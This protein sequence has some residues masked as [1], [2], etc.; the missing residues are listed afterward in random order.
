MTGFLFFSIIVLACVPPVSKD[1]LVHHLAV[2][3]LYLKHGKI[4]EI[5]FMP[6]SYYP[7]NLDMLYLIPLYFGNDIIPKYIHFSFALL[8]GLC[9]FE[10]LRRRTRLVYGL[11]GFLFFLSIPIIVKLSITAYVD[12][13]LIFFSTASLLLLLR[14]IASGFKWRF[15]ILS[16]ILCGLATGTKYNG[17]ITL[18]L[19]TLFVPFFYSKLNRER[20][21]NFMQSAGRGVVFFLTAVTIF[22]PWAV[23]NYKWTKNPIY[24]LHDKWFNPPEVLPA[25][26][27][28][29]A[30]GK[31]VKRGLLTDRFLMYGETSWEIALLPLRVFFQGKDGNPQYFDGKLNPMLLFLPVFAFF[32]RRE[33][34]ETI[35]SEK[36]ILLAFAVLFFGFTFFSYA[37]RIRYIS[38]IIPPLVILAVLGMKNMIDTATKIQNRIWK[39]PIILVIAGSGIFSLWLNAYY[40]YQQYKEV[41]PV[42]YLM[43]SVSRDEYIDRYRLEYPAIRYINESLPDDAK[44][45]FIFLGKRGYYCNK[46]YE[47]GN[48][49]FRAAIKNAAFPGQFF[50]ALKKKGFT[51]LLIRYDIFDKWRKDRYLFSDKQ[52]SLL[53]QFMSRFTRLLFFKWGYG[54]SRLEDKSLAVNE[55]TT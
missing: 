15:L 38:P 18:F 47:L 46:D 11:G 37:L 45:M 8:T 52:Q 19:L 40:I 50:S 41:A 26:P 30:S 34:N 5:P 33:D 2:P 29:E 13:G 48:G 51:H 10:Y 44:I 3:K 35:R 49:N 4:Y 39:K 36:R 27:E 14:W 42:G 54:V 32:G 17:L 55:S 28:E 21:P 24:P 20:R 23:K 43:G 25:P 31:K 53:E 6:F 9:I 12:L 22:S 7:M 16:A 1:A